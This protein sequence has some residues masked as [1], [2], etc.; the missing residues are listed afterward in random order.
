[1]RRYIQGLA[2]Y[3]VLAA[4]L[5]QR[6]GMSISRVAL[7]EWV[8]ELGERAKTPLEISIELEPKWGGFL[9]ID[10]KAIYVRG[11]EHCLLI[12]V[13]Q[14]TH[15]I[16]HA[17]VLEAE[18]GEGFAKLETEARLDAGYPLYGVVSDLGPGFADSHRDHFGEVP[19]QACRIHCD[20]RLDQD[21]PKMKRSPKAALHQELKDRIRAV[22]Y[23]PT[24]DD[25]WHLLCALTGDRT[26]YAGVGR[27][28]TI[29]SLVRNFDLYV[30]HHFVDGLPADNNITENVIKQLKKKLRLMESF[31]SPESAERYTRL[32]VGCYRFKRFTDS[33]NGNNGKS[34]LEVA[35][36]DLQGRDWL[37]FLLDR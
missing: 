32:L 25:A 15:D 34:P 31:V 28:D 26:R 36:V 22:L 29:G 16:V 21:I 27:V 20:R 30:V 7:N 5:E 4:M 13:D 9:G 33:C 12:G 11:R 14:L 17:L 1:M 6:H 19:F 18:T 35:G 2:S 10:G 37:S 24:R 3:R 23:A 8:L